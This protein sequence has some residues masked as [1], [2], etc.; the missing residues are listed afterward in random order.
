MSQENLAKTI[1]KYLREDTEAT[2]KK[3]V[4]GMLEKGLLADISSEDV[5]KE[6]KSIYDTC[7][8]CVETGDYLKA[9][10]YAKSR[11]ISGAV[12]GLAITDFL[13]G[14]LLL[15][16][17]SVEAIRTH[18]RE[19]K[20]L[21]EILSVYRTASSQIFLT[22]AVA[23]SQQSIVL[24]KAPLE[25]S[26]EML[27]E[28]IFALVSSAQT[29]T[30]LSD[31]RIIERVAAQHWFNQTLKMKL[32][33]M[34]TAYEACLQYRELADQTGV[35]KKELLEIHE[36][37][38]TAVEGTFLQPCSYVKACSWIND[39]AGLQLI[40]LRATPFVMAIELITGKVY[41][42]QLTKFDREKA[43]IVQAIPSQ[44]EFSVLISGK[45]GSGTVKVSE[46]DLKSMDLDF[47]DNVYVTPSREGAKASKFMSFS[48]SKLPSGTIMIGIADA[49]KLGVQERDV[50]YIKR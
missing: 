1:T 14:L 35:M 31:F 43:C 34:K 13:N 10:E 42:S 38:T 49:V 29:V 30:G 9:E 5:E 21:Q 44:R 48:Q 24:E 4:S 7:V 27:N 37:G 45:L 25:A 36:K 3:W 46:A 41:K 11:A 39:D 19:Q 40:C 12:K 15:R 33:K 17:I 47:V 20:S 6:S 26:S 50:V 22:C 32:K 16:D 18:F 8:K 2:R 28:W 23:Y